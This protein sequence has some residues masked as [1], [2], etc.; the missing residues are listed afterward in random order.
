MRAIA[1]ASREFH[2]GIVAAVSAILLVMCSRWPLRAEDAK[3]AEA[4]LAELQQRATGGDAPAIFALGE[5]YRH[6]QGTSIDLRKAAEWYGKAAQ[7]DHAAAMTQLG[8][9]YR[10]GQGV[11]RNDLQALNCFRRAAELDHPAAMNYLGLMYVAGEGV[12]PDP[13]PSTPP[14]P[15]TPSAL[16][17]P[18]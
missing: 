16:C 5:C 13:L 11:G 6:G 1:P 9:M 8:R 4:Q 12:F 7:K 10:G 14:A 15:G 3:S 2:P 18:I 17:R